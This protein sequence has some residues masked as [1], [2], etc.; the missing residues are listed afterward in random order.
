ML[1]IEFNDQKISVPQSWADLCLADYEK[2]F[3]H[4]PEDKMEYVHFIAGICK[5]DSEWLLH[6][7]TQLFD[8]ISEAVSFAFDTDFE[9]ATRVN[10]D[11]RDFFISPSD[12]LTLGEWIDVEETFNGDSETKISE[13][14]AIVCRPAGESYHPDTAA[15]RQ[16]TFRN[17]PCE[18]ALPLLAFFLY[19]KKKSEEISLHY[20]MVVAQANRF[21]KDTKTFVINGGGI[22]QLPIWQRIKF[23]YLTRLLRKQLSK[24]SDSSFTG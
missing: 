3:K 8:A 4:H 1:Q 9:P 15:V 20:S 5:L 13:T 2:W 11:G 24:F 14:L 21:L 18:K 7:P 17:L 16:E 12:E 23:I 19:K 22:K 10:I 6:S